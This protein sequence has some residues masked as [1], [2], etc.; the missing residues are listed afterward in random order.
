MHIHT[1]TLCLCLFFLIQGDTGDGETQVSG[2]PFKNDD[3]G[4]GDIMDDSPMPFGENQDANIIQDVEMEDG[5]FLVVE[6]LSQLFCS[7][8]E[9]AV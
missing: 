6:L 8:L 7:Y 5:M 3:S 9:L 4:G 2:D 1:T